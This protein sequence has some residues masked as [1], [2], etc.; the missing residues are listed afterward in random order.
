MQGGVPYIP[1][2]VSPIRA[3]NISINE[4]GRRIPGPSAWIRA[5]PFEQ[6]T[7]CTHRIAWCRD[8]S[9]IV[10]RQTFAG[11]RLYIQD[12]PSAWRCSKTKAMP[13]RQRQRFF[14]CVQ[15]L[16]KQGFRVSYAHATTCSQYRTIEKGLPRLRMTARSRCHWLFRGSERGASST[17]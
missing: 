14:S 1:I 15:K 17:H 3:S 7:S 5:V 16:P 8:R 2:P 12:H 6:H 4:S 10:C 13:G 9:R 11:R